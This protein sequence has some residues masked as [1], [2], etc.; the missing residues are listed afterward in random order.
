MIVTLRRGASTDQGT[1][2]VLAFGGQVLHTLELPW[3]GNRAQRSCIPPGSYGCSLVQSPRL[4]QVYGVHD[5]P[6]RSAVLI[7]SANLAGDV[8]MG[9]TTQLQGC[10]APCMRVGLMRNNAGRMQAAGLVSRPALAQ[11]HSWDQGQPFTL[12]ISE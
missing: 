9:Y 8:D 5:V 6:G 3:R 12:E 10:I 11:L 1:F 7:H 2:G 4:G